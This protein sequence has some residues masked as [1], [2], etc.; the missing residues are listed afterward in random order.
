MHFLLISCW[1]PFI[2]QCIWPA[3]RPVV[4]GHSEAEQTLRRQHEATMVT[5]YKL[6]K[7]LTSLS[8]LVKHPILSVER[9]SYIWNAVSG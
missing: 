9:E 7:Q 8:F 1:S 5:L 4:L 3:F 6:P 2:L